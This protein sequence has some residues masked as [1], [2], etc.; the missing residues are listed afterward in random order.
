MATVNIGPNEVGKPAPLYWR[1]FTRA[2]V[3]LVPVIVDI[4][5]LWGG[6]PDHTLAHAALIAS[7]FPAIITG[8]GML[9]SNGQEY[10]PVGTADALKTVTGAETT[11]QAIV[12]AT[13][14]PPADGKPDEPKEGK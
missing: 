3:F 14:L 5:N 8:I 11:K 10:A 9:I 1:R 7:H 6:I 4:M 2:S 12:M 13:N